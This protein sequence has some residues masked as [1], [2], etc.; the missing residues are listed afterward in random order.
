MPDLA[1]RVFHG[2]PRVALLSLLGGEVASCSGGLLM[3]V[4]RSAQACSH[5]HGL[6]RCRVTLRAEVRPR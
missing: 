3:A 6:G 2:D 5:G 4:N 1:V